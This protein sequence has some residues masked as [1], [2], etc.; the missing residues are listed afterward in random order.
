MH[1]YIHTHIHTSFYMCN[2]HCSFQQLQGQ[3]VLPNVLAP[4]LQ[5]TV[6]PYPNPY[7]MFSAA[8]LLF[9]PTTTHYKEQGS[10]QQLHVHYHTSN[11]Q[12]LQGKTCFV[13]QVLFLR[14]RL[15]CISEMFYSFHFSVIVFRLFQL[16]FFPC[17][18]K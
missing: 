9:T 6:N 15:I 14:E 7:L 18:F 13:L 4:S 16:I 11:Q 2:F 12:Q 3:R 5:P 17:I 10:N 1:A 8:N